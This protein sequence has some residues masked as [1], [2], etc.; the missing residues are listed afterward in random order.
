MTRM[1]M[2]KI[3]G[4]RRKHLYPENNLC[5]KS[6]K[7]KGEGRVEQEH[8]L[9]KQRKLQA[10]PWPERLREGLQHP[11]RVQSKK[12]ETEAPALGKDFCC[13]LTGFNPT[14]MT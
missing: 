14:D 2:G 12:Q 13:S 10:S 11:G 8:C 1:N 7:L 5:K 4:E 6:W 3:W 9:Q